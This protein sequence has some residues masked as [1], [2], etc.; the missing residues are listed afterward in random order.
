MN[1]SG[2]YGGKE[3]QVG[4]GREQGRQIQGRILEDAGREQG[5]Q[6]LGRIL[7]KAGREQ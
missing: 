1:P 5:R 7:E 2:K 3:T 6:I 4:K